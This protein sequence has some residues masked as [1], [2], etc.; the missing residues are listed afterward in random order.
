MHARWSWLHRLVVIAL[1]VGG[2]SS[3]SVLAATAVSAPPESTW[4]QQMR[5]RVFGL[6]VPG[7]TLAG[8][9][10]DV[11]PI[12][13]VAGVRRSAAAGAA[14]RVTVP[15]AAT[16]GIAGK[17]GT[18]LK[19]AGTAATSLFV[20]DLT[21]NA[22]AGVY[23]DHFGFSGLTGYESAGLLCDLTRVVD[24]DTA[25]GIVPIEGYEPN[26]DVVA[27]G[28]PAGW[29][30]GD[31]YSWES[32]R[33][34]HGAYIGTVQWTLTNTPTFRQAATSTSG[35]KWTLTASIDAVCRNMYQSPDIV[36]PLT[37]VN[38]VV[39]DAS[40]K[41]SIYGINP[42]NSA[43]TRWLYS[44]NCALSSGTPAVMTWEFDTTKRTGGA[45]LGNFDHLELT[46]TPNSGNAA[47]G[48]AAWYPEGHALWTP[49]TEEDP[50]RWWRTEWLCED[51][52]S[53]AAESERYRESDP[54]WAVPAEPVC[55]G[56]ALASTKVWQYGVGTDPSLLYEWSA[57]AELQAWADA[58]PE[59]GTGSCVLELH[60]IDAE[61]GTRLACFDNP[62]LCV[63]WYT[64][65]Q[66]QTNYQCTYGSHDVALD[67]CTVY[68]PTFD[69]AKA[70]QGVDYADPLTGQEPIPAGTE[71]PGGGGVGECPPP[72]KWNSLVNAWWYYQGVKCAGYELFY[73]TTTPST[74]FQRVQR[75][76]ETSP[77]GRMQVALV[78]GLDGW[79]VAETGCSGPPMVLPEILGGQTL[80][81]W[82]TCSGWQA[83]WAPNI[84]MLSTWAV[85]IAIT[86]SCLKSLGRGFGYDMGETPDAD[87]DKK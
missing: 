61:T 2:I 38:V 32:T 35:V 71:V 83:Q 51:G 50:E 37:G 85:G 53:G 56:S 21:Y 44:T 5:Q 58:Y 10:R 87:K 20:L 27:G 3:T 81:V 40:G 9:S 23:T 48:R 77:P 36:G 31:S 73:P 60:R 52:S 47:L 19:G 6:R 14:G 28:Q 22:F 78:D 75:T 43:T 57:P 1:V 49:G 64:D 11:T 68:R 39:T 76:W 65:P 46:L 54:E 30:P 41:A 29:A 67:E 16:A 15:S 8:A 7:S 59:C 62:S 17:A 4:A 79:R 82:S 55:D 66:K 12:Q 86:F 70:A 33:V 34:L 72:F 13:R 63:D 69:Y 80:Y 45:V 25:C 18:A 26:S 74:Q 84:K 42:G 24:T